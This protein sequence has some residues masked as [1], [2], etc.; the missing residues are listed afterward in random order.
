MALGL[1]TV[2]NESG[3]SAPIPWD[4]HGLPSQAKHSDNHGP[5]YTAYDSSAL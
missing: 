3:D 2:K 4:G 5:I 1:G